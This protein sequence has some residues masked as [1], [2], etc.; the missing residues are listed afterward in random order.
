VI[1]RA[2]SVWTHSISLALAFSAIPAISQAQE[3]QAN[4]GVLEEVIVTAQKREQ[5]LLDVPISIGVVSGEKIGDYNIEGMAELQ[6]YVPNFAVKDTPANNEIYIRGI[7]SPSGAL[8][9]EQS[10]GLFIDGVYGGR[11]R[12]FMAPFMDIERVEVLRGPQG[13][14]V[15]K[16]T[17]AG[18]IR[19]MTARPSDEKE[20]SISGEYEFE[21]DSYT[22]TGLAS[23]PLSDDFKGRLAFRYEDQGGYVYNSLLERD[24]PEKKNLVIR[25]TGVWQA[26][27]AVEVIGKIEYTDFDLTGFPF[28]QVPLGGSPDYTRQTDGLI[29]DD[30][31]ETETFTVTLT[32][33]AELGEN[34]LTSITAYGDIA[35]LYLVD[36][37]FSAL[38]FLHFPFQEDYQQFSQEFRIV[39]PTGGKFN[40]IAGV[41]YIH[42][43]L[44][45]FRQLN[46]AFLSTVHNSWYEQ[47]SDTLSVYGEG[48]WQLTSKLDATVSLRYTYED[49][50]A[51]LR[52]EQTGLPLFLDYPI[53]ADRTEN[54]FDPTVTLQYQATEDTMLFVRYA[55]GSKGGGFAGASRTVTEDTFEMEEETATSYEAG[56]KL[57]AYDHRMTFSAVGFF[58][59]YDDLQVSA[60][61]GTGFDFGNAGE[62]ETK[63]VELDFSW[64]INPEW[65]FDGSLGWLDAEYTSFP[66]AGCVAPKHIIP[67]CVEDIAGS[68][69]HHAPEWSGLTSL[70]YHANFSDSLEFRGNVALVF[71]DD[72]YTHLSLMPESLQESYTKLDMRLAIGAQSGRWELALIG[73]N[74]TNEKTISQAF[75]TPFSAAPGA[76]PDHNS[77]TLLLDRPRT[78]AL[79]GT[80]RF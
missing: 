73:K 52:R 24:E 46:F 38:P 50:G 2:F 64:L 59:T 27:D 6:A 32:V 74:L 77:A 69:L 57:W 39:S 21:Y 28:G 78:I 37:D 15:G 76:I 79:R 80:L 16:N 11:A 13:A 51:D 65:R 61:N 22:L 10:V 70:D 19:I 23:G 72:S 48:S 49:K 4:E 58:T 29:G 53:S 35:T 20:L 68:P 33:N 3:P 41:S 47:E 30:S 14:V 17:S 63:G 44:D 9:L 66:G 1:K 40:Y 75:E 7:G 8:S 45:V 60:F 31:D 43:E 42:N 71:E 54:L 18:A 56:A 62:A 34:T 55:R 26:S 12:M 5:N 25:G 36:G 67:G